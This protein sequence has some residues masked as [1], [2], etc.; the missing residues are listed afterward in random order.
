M[1]LKEQRSPWHFH[2]FYL[3]GTVQWSEG[4]ANKFPKTFLLQKYLNAVFIACREHTNLESPPDR[5][6][7]QH[8][9][10]S[11]TFLISH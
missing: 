4:I 3:H 7:V 8:G 2:P 11:F 6:A 1:Q 9:L 10:A 5:S